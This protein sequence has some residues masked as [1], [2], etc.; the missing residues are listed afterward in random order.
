MGKPTSGGAGGSGGRSRANAEYTQIAGPDFKTPAT[1]QEV[2]DSNKEY[3]NF[4]EP[5]YAKQA[6]RMG[7]ASM[8]ALVQWETDNALINDTLRKGGIPQGY[9]SQKTMI[10]A[11]TAALDKSMQPLD[12]NI[13]VYRGAK[14]PGLTSMFMQGTL[15]GAT[16]TDNGFISTSTNKNIAIR[17]YKRNVFRSLRDAAI[18][19]IRTPKGTQVAYTNPNGSFGIQNEIIVNRG[20]SIRIINSRMENNVLLIDAEVV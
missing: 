17:Y 6:E 18:L 10:D 8:A 9:A 12:T 20:N 11:V 14:I 4:A 16:L 1:V 13:V 2:Q 5:R 15:N 7:E 19:T 3:R